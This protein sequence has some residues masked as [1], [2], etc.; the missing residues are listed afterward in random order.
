MSSTRIIA[1][2]VV[3]WGGL[4]VA[5]CCLL[6]F[7]GCGDGGGPVQPE[8]PPQDV[9]ASP[10]AGE[11][12]GPL[13]D[14][15]RETTPGDLQQLPDRSHSESAAQA[16]EGQG[17]A[18]V[19]ELPDVYLPEDFEPVYEDRRKHDPVLPVPEGWI[20]L[21]PDYPVFADLKEKRVAVD[22]RIVQNHALLE[23]LACPVDS[24]KEH[25]SVVGVFS[26]SQLIHAALLAVGAKPG[27]PVRFDPE[28]QPA[29]GTSIAI[30][31]HWQDE[32]GQDQS[33]DARQWVR[34]MQTKEEL[35]S[36]WVFG[37][38]LIYRDPETGEE[39][40]LAEG[41]ELICVSNFAT[42]TLDLPIA[43][44]ADAANQL[45]E[46]NTD[47]IP[48]LGTLVRMILVPDLSTV[49]QDDETPPAAGDDDS[50]RDENAEQADR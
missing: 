28:Y 45:F 31:A 44:S 20:K 5:A 12:E 48:P 4:A 24:G 26:N 13:P 15:D 18:E 37:G 46:A 9:Q 50:Q 43:S 10:P 21:S 11:T 27:S 42:A 41:G 7:A 14:E 39:Y 1:S 6:S 35:Q 36:N 22:G 25:E 40:Y 33:I 17:G 23:M 30:E 2:L 47:K 8:R 34:N 29:S 32:D 49:P 38:S 19:K 16:E 3:R